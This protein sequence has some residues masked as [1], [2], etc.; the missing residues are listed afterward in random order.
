MVMTFSQLRELKDQEFEAFSTKAAS[1]CSDFC[2]STVSNML[3]AKL[4]FKILS[5]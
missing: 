1:P 5:D 3:N 4:T 2:F